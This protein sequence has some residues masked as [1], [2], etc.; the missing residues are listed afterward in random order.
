[1]AEIHQ[2]LLSHFS[3]LAE[4]L[5]GKVVVKDRDSR[6]YSRWISTFESKSGSR[7]GWVGSTSSLGLVGLRFKSQWRNGKVRFSFFVTFESQSWKI[8]KLRRV[9]TRILLGP[10]VYLCSRSQE[11][12][13]MVLLISITTQ[14]NSSIEATL[15][16]CWII[17]T[18]LSLKF[19]FFIIVNF[20]S[21]EPWLE[22]VE[23]D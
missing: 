12:R 4:Y 11:L 19:T 23:E 17:W 7:C 5:A 21:S 15:Y 10:W 6:A 1:L 8:A 2:A 13:I 16:H 22:I 14:L 3:L 18:P 20:Y 9:E